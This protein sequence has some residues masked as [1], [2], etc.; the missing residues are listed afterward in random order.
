MLSRKHTHAQDNTPF[1]DVNVDNL[2]NVSDAFQEAFYEALKHKGI[3]NY[4]RAIESLDKGIALDDSHPILYFEKGKNYM[5]LKK[6]EQAESNFL[7]TLELKPNQKP[8][9]ALLYELYY[10]TRDYEQAEEVVKQL[11]SFDVNYKEDLARVY[12]A[13]KR[14]T[15]A[16]TLLD[17]LDVE[18]GRDIR[19]DRLR[20]QLNRHSGGT[21]LK[22]DALNKELEKNAKSEQDYLKLI[23]LYQEQ[24]NMDKAY[25]T[26]LK[27]QKINPDADAVHLVLY[28]TDI[29]KGNTDNAI[30]A[31]TK[32]LKSDKI[33]AKAKHRVLNDFLSFVNKNPS[34]EPQL[35]SAIATFDSQVKGSKVYQ[36]LGMY[37]SKK[38]AQDKALSYFLKSLDTD[39]ENV[40]ILKQV[41]KTEIALGKYNKA[42]TR[43]KDAIELYPSQ[44]SLYYSYG[45]ALKA[46]GNSEEAN[47][48]WE[49]GVDYVIDDVALEA[50]FYEQLAESYTKLGDSNKAGRYALQMRKLRGTN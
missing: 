41:L 40:D 5:T 6:Y 26:A 15:E 47:F 44:P 50:N 39:A 10:R 9:M 2:G 34:Y 4:E 36:N 37:Y 19:R 32:V 31:M 46:L 17:E 21:K 29:N 33:S 14:Y 18:K 43:A 22:E 1:A 35:E 48:Q 49:T 28:K 45:L 16:L 38:G 24:G 23:Y 27:L 3:E 11:I 30:N 8:V 20:V 13:T 25:E 42:A 7:K 12:K